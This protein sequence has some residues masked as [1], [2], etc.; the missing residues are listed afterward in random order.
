MKYKRQ[1]FT[2]SISRTGAAFFVIAALLSGTFAV[3]G[4]AQDGQVARPRTDEK[5]TRLSEDQRILHVL[6][7]LGFGARPGDI[8]RVKA[9]GLDGY[10]NQQL[11]PQKISDSVAD[12]K[13]KN[14]ATLNM[15]TAELYEKFPQPGQLLRQ[16]ERRGELPAELAAARDNRVKGDA[17]AASSQPKAGEMEMATADAKKK[18]TSQVPIRIRVTIRN[19]VRHYGS[20]TQR[21]VCNCPSAY[22][23]SCKR[24]EFFAR[25]IASDSCR[26]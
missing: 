14:L 9:V 3:L 8:A 5:I 7:R 10:I 17:N 6:N 12:A 19:I 2:S 4:N 23:L 26:K 24:L 1:Q 16:L 15:T 20:T 21:M 13:V 22:R 25:S 11:N 18:S